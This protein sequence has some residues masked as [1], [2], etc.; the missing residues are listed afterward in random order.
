[1]SYEADAEDSN[2]MKWIGTASDYSGKKL[3]G[4]SYTIIAFIDTA[5]ADEQPEGSEPYNC[6][7]GFQLASDNAGTTQSLD[8]V[9]TLSEF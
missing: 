8:I 3:E 4:G 2:K 7:S 6:A 1:M 9:K 5:T